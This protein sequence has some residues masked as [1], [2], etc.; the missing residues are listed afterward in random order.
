MPDGPDVASNNTDDQIMERSG[1]KTGPFEKSSLGHQNA[2]E[3]RW[4]R[5][6]TLAYRLL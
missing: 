1:T 3:V 2:S 4:A 6:L 5:V